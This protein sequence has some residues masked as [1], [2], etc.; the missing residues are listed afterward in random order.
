MKRCKKCGRVQ[1]I[2]NFYRAGGTRDGHRSDCKACNLA[3]K[4]LRYAQNPTPYIERAKAWQRANKERVAQVQRARR[5]RPEVK[6]A[7][8]S[9][10]LKRKYGITAD[11]YDSMLDAQGG[12][13]AICGRPPRPD[14]S[15]HV[16][17]E[18]TS[19]RVRS[20]LCFPCNNLLGDAHD[21]PSLLRAAADYLDRHV[22]PLIRQRLAELVATRTN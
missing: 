14:I 9:A 20:L 13:C 5:Q 16:D 2:E 21:D 1:P 18:P 6:R 8:R 15:L 22:E 4:H 12:G 11:E 17:H 19:G 7:E 10:Y 3:E